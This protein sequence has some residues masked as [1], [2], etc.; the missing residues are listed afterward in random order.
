MRNVQ[1][2]KDAQAEAE[3][4]LKV[5][6]AFLHSASAGFGKLAD[7][8][9]N[10]R[11]L[12][13][14]AQQAL[15]C[16]FGSS[17]LKIRSAAVQYIFLG[18]SATYWFS[19]GFQLRCDFLQDAVV[20][21]SREVQTFEDGVMQIFNLVAPDV[22]GLP[23]THDDNDHT[24]GTKINDEVS[25]ATQVGTSPCMRAILYLALRKGL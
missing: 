12:V 19:A 23:G 2:S 6:T 1:S 21:S 9:L 16:T 5:R 15:V 17:C 13:Q 11:Q 8:L 3:D 22:S 20:A 18:C 24:L 25:M 10:Q 4:L 7:A 14:H